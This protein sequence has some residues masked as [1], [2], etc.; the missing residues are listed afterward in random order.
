[1]LCFNGAFTSQAFENHTE[2]MIKEIGSLTAKQI[3]KTDRDAWIDFYYSRYEIAPIEIHPE[4]MRIDLQEQEVSVYNQWHMLTGRAPEY[5]TCPGL[6]STCTVEYTGD[7]ALFNLTPSTFSLSTTYDLD[8]VE[9][10][11]GRGIG[12][13]HFSYEMR[14]D[15][16][17]ADAIR[18]HFEE[19]IKD[20][21]ECASRVNSDVEKFNA[22]LRTSIELAVD[23]R[24]RQLDAF[25]T[26]RQ[27]LNLPLER[28]KDAPMAKPIVLPKRRM[29]FSEPKPS[30]GERSYSISD[31]DYRNITDIIDNCCSMMEAAP[32]SYIGFE[33]EQL[34]DHMLSVLNTHYVNASGETFRNNGKTDIHIP[35]SGDHAAYIAECKCWHG[36][37][38]FLKAIDQLFSYTTWRDTKVSVIVFNKNVRNYE[39]VLNTIDG[40]LNDNSV[41]VTRPKHSQWTCRVQNERDERIMHVTVQVFNLFSE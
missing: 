40:A 41:S 31:V 12:R 16:A 19:K 26:L 17:T 3:D 5:I 21:M 29:A 35:C 37:K 15:G 9:Q 39:H 25:A 23:K 4:T 18:S 32:K 8:R 20:F 28:V 22:G 11:D 13:L 14:Q 10:L 6:R 27:N 30:D 36:A 38:A 7:Y 1:M 33:E 2:R 34:R 24:I